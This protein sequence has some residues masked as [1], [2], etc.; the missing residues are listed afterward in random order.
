VQAFEYWVIELIVIEVI[1][2]NQEVI[3]SVAVLAGGQSE[4]MGRD[5][6]FIEIGG[7]PIIE[8]ILICVESLTDDV[9]I[10]TNSPE[11]YSQYGLRN[12][13]DIYPNKGAL[14]GVYSALE[15][16]THPYVL[17]LACD[18]PFLNIALLRHLINLAPTA[19]AIVP[20]FKLQRPEVLHAVYGKRCLPVVKSRLLTN[21]LRIADF[22]DDLS[23]RYVR[24]DE[25]ARF[26]P[27]FHTFFNVNTLA[28]WQQAESI[29]N[30]LD[31][32]KTT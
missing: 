23:V 30:T 10:S 5:K 27:Y 9:L 4:R 32:P 22:F 7:R 18:M 6:A 29:A 28:D 3:I 31:H 17:I 11:K 8:R 13:S 12:I 16:A 15:A 20:I 26:D 24:R 21:Q 19:D 14:G 1:R 2:I 25:I